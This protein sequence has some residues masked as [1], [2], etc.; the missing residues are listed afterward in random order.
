VS[1][2]SK[3]VRVQKLEF[4]LSLSCVGVVFVVVVVVGPR[5]EF[6]VFLFGICFCFFVLFFLYTSASCIQSSYMDMMSIWIYLR[7]P[8]DFKD[9]SYVSP[10]ACFKARLGDL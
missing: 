9:K 2:V 4:L 8:V 7:K 1:S 3:L 6:V 5:L 10:P